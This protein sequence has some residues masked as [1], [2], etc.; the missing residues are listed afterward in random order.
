MS[1]LCALALMTAV[2]CGLWSV[3]SAAVG[4]V[5]W[6]GF[7]GCTTYFACDCKG[8][9]G[10]KR[11]I[12]CNLLGVLCAMFAI[13]LGNWIPILNSLGFCS[14]LI[15]FIMCMLSK[16]KLFS[17]CPGIFVGCFST[18]A[19]NGNLKEIIPALL[20]GAF[21]GLA[22]DYSGKWFYRIISKNQE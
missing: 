22:C 13:W 15:S 12:A 4:L 16:Y 3:I 21:L 18:F 17:Y 19:A 9:M 1:S 5:T 2:C 7:A 8:I 10:V 14:A 20:V 11:T 6:I